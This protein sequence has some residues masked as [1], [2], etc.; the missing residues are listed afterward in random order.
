MLHGT[1]FGTVFYL[2]ALIAC[3]V[4][5]Y[6]FRKSHKPMSGFTWS[7]LSFLIKMCIRDSLH[8]YL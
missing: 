5:I 8:T 2:A 6:R 7:V 4:N 1:V 3:V